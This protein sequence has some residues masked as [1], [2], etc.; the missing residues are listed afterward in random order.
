M[1]LRNHF[2]VQWYV[3]IN[4][5]MEDKHYLTPIYAASAGPGHALI[6]KGGDTT[7]LRFHHLLEAHGLAHQ[8]LNTTRTLIQ[9]RGLTTHHATTEKPSSFRPRVGRRN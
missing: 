9:A 2:L 1:I 4:P 6:V 3:L 5:K 8:F 7:I